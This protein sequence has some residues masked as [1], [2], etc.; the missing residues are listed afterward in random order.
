MDNGRLPKTR[1]PTPVIAAGLEMHIN[2]NSHKKVGI[3]L[4]SFF[5]I[6]R[7]KVSVWRWLQKFGPL[8]DG[9]V[10][11]IRAGI[12]EAWQTDETAIKIQGKDHWCWMT[13]DEDM[14][15]ILATDVTEWGRKEERAIALFRIAK[16]HSRVRP[17]TIVTDG[18]AA[19]AAGVRR[20]SYRLSDSNGTVH[21]SEIHFNGKPAINQMQERLSATYKDRRRPV[22]RFKS[23]GGA[24]NF[25]PG[26]VVQYD[27]IRPHESLGEH[28]PARIAGIHLSCEDGWG[29]LS[30]WATNWHTLRQM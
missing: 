19:C 12:S 5:R 27:W 7:H 4:G 10:G 2:G 3:N 11:N 8:V 14:R 26:F 25:S 28:T 9:L 6:S 21:L 24:L 20:N 29:D 17:K 15:C 13:M 18:L 16:A 22:R 30:K 23:D 1:T